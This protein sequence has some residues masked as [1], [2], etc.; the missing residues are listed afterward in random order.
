ML[1]RGNVH[2]AVEIAELM[3]KEKQPNQGWKWK[4]NRIKLNCISALKPLPFPLL[5][6]LSNREYLL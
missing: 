2:V 4:A 6:E 1:T 5:Q 3:S